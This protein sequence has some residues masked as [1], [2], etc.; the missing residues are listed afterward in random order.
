MHTHNIT[1]TKSSQDYLG[2]MAE[3]FVGD[4]SMESMPLQI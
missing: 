1:T 3:I 2:D 4:V